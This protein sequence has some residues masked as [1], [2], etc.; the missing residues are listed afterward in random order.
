MRVKSNAC[1]NERIS[2]LNGISGHNYA[3]MTEAMLSTAGKQPGSIRLGSKSGN[4]EA[5]QRLR[6][7]LFVTLGRAIHSFGL[8]AKQFG[9]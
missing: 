6:R 5:V 4:L 8:A 9:L 7:W 3:N 1:Q 2:D